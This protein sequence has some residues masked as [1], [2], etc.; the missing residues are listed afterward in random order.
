MDVEGESASETTVG[1]ETGTEVIAYGGVTGGVWSSDEVHPAVSSTNRRTK[2]TERP[3]ER[4]LF[5]NGIFDIEGDEDYAKKSGPSI[6]MTHYGDVTLNGA[7]PLAA[8]ASPTEST[9]V[10]RIKHEHERI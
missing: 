9:H 8:W 10:D 7:P 3:T 4:T 5:I 1:T 2:T 6:F